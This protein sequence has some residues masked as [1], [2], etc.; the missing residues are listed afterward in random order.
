MQLSS[1]GGCGSLPYSPSV[2]RRM[3]LLNDVEDSQ[4][5]RL[6]F[7]SMSRT[8]YRVNYVRRHAGCPIK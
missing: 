5:T 1:S 7:T 4:K 6:N 3:L 2:Q 8:E